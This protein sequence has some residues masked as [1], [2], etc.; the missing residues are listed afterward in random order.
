MKLFPRMKKQERS[1]ESLNARW[2]NA[3]RAN[4]RVYEKE[5]GTLLAGVALTEDCDSLFPIVPEEQWAIEGK[6]ISQ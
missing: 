2:E 3:Y 1:K 4:P 5:D 6:S